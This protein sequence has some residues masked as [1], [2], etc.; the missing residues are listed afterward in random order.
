MRILVV[1]K[2]SAWELFSSSKDPHVALFMQESGRDAQFF[3]HSHQAQKTAIETVKSALTES[4]AKVKMLYRSEL[5]ETVTLLTGILNVASISA[6]PVG[7]AASKV[8][9]VLLTEYVDLS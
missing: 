6:V 3:E 4:G 1:Y 9:V 7:I 2:K 5:S 8:N